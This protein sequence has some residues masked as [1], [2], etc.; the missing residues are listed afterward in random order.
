MHKPARKQGRYA[1]LVLQ[2]PIRFACSVTTQYR[3][4]LRLGLCNMK[5]P[6][7]ETTALEKLHELQNEFARTIRDK[8]EHRAEDCRTCA[9]PGGC[10]LDAHFVNVRITRLEAVA[11]C[12]VIDQLPDQKR[13]KVYE[14]VDNAIA[15]YRLST[16]GNAERSFFAC[17]LFEKGTG[18]LVHDKAKPLPCIAHACYEKQED[19]PPD[20][21]LIEQEGRVAKLNEVTY[22]KTAISIPLPLAIRKF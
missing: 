3:P 7:S 10:C 5:K 20:R 21:L 12:R 11:I 8:F 18:C 1:T 2:N 22:R 16:A 4:R 6:V 9:T 15:T 13:N 14:R 17:P 19:L